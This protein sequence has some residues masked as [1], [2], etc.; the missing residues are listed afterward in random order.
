MS[1]RTYSGDELINE[2][3]DTLAQWDGD[4]LAETAQTILGHQ[5]IYTEE[6]RFSVV[7]E[8]VAEIQ[9]PAFYDNINEDE[10]DR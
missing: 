8:E 3:R 7:E 10:F 4:A 9:D 1:E 2:I 6:G 5:V